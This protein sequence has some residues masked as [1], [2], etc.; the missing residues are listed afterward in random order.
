MTFLRLSHTWRKKAQLSCGAQEEP[1]YWQ[2]GFPHKEM[3]W[4]SKMLSISNCLM[5]KQELCAPSHCN[6]IP[7]I[8]TCLTL[9]CEYFL[10]M[11]AIHQYTKW[12][13]ILFCSNVNNTQVNPISRSWDW[14]GIR[15]FYEPTKTLYSK[16]LLRV[17]CL[18]AALS[19]LGNCISTAAIWKLK[20]TQDD[21]SLRSVSFWWVRE[22]LS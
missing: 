19:L 11:N 1:S 20:R 6:Y 21:S 8:P 2:I 15:K 12:K 3:S 22:H 18:W 7:Q 16:I 17:A 9:T 13:L 5:N 4:S 14:F 10:I